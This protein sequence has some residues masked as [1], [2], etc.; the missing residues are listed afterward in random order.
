MLLIY[1][2]EMCLQKKVPESKIYISGKRTA[3]QAIVRKSFTEKKKHI[4]S[5]IRG[6]AK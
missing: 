5:I 1:R 6:K 3:N 4:I 2:S